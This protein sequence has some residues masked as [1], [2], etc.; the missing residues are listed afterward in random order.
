MT[1]SMVSSAP[2]AAAGSSAG[3]AGAGSRAVRVRWRCL[4]VRPDPPAL[5]S[6]RGVKPVSRSRHGVDA[7]GRLAPGC[8]RRQRARRTP[9]PARVPGG[10]R[11][12]GPA[13]PFARDRI[14]GP[15]GGS[16]WPAARDR[17]HPCLSR[18]G[19][20]SHAAGRWPRRCARP[21][22]ACGLAGNRGPGLWRPHGP[23]GRRPGLVPGR[24]GARPCGA[25]A[26]VRGA[27][28]RGSPRVVA[29]TLSAGAGGA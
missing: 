27:V 25:D 5:C 3:V 12:R 20:S 18:G 6:G 14:A 23:S 1:S 15:A 24:R 8:A 29:G 10:G 9:E 11:R 7:S 28:S 21:A 22:T 13:A 19:M 17:Q 26:R 2:G 16:G 4:Y